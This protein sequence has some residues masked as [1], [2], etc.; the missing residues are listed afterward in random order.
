M[1]R[2]K[3]TTQELIDAARTRLKSFPFSGDLHVVG[4][5][6]ESLQATANKKIPDEHLRDVGMMLV[7]ALAREKPEDTTEEN[8][9]A[10]LPKWWIATAKEASII[11]RNKQTRG[12]KSN[13]ECR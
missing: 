7:T 8:L 5:L 6:S 2:M 4:E 11:L 1:P 3:R 10:D 13:S 12:A 9:V